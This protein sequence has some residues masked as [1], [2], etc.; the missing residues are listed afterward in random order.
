MLVLALLL[1]LPVAARAADREFHSLVERMSAYY[2]KRPMK[3]TGWLNFLAN[4]FTPEGTS[5]FQLVIFDDIDASRLP[6][7]EEFESSLESLIGPS[8]QPFVRVHDVHSGDWTF[9]YIRETR[10]K[11]FEMLIVCIDSTDAVLIKMQVKPDA[12]R[13][14]VNEPVRRG[15][16]S[17]YRATDFR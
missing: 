9:I 2:Q 4:R 3:F 5:H 15:R 16:D 7:D 13:E 12:M 17:R 10:E 14:W 8:Y 11:S 1:L 6:P